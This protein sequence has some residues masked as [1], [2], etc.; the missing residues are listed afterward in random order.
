MIL[1]AKN[2]VLKIMTE[3][4]Y[5]V[6][7]STEDELFLEAKEEGRLDSLIRIFPDYISANFYCKLIKEQSKDS[8]IKILSM[9]IDE[10]FVYDSV[11]GSIVELWEMD[12]FGQMQFVDLIYDPTA[13]VH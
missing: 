9:D 12:N 7:L 1:L 5:V 8:K 10:L 11:W 4:L 13:M 2:S 3:K 6:G